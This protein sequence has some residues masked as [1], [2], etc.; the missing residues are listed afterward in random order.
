MRC[1]NELVRKRGGSRR[2]SEHAQPKQ[3][4][5]STPRSNH[6]SKCPTPRDDAFRGEYFTKKVFEL[7]EESVQSSLLRQNEVQESRGNGGV[8]FVRP[9]QQSTFFETFETAA[10][11]EAGLA[12]LLQATS[13]E[14]TKYEG[15]RNP[16][17]ELNESQ[18]E[19]EIRCIEECLEHS[20]NSQ[21]KLIQIA[22]ELEAEER[23]VRSA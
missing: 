10:A 22:H 8:F 13:S 16:F 19:H 3:G 9:M 14:D 23:K 5:R 7:N 1:D 11:G 20:E 4:F 12:M 21:L 18:I 2:A 15:K 6:S 17:G